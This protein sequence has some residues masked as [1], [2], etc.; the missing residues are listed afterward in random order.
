[1]PRIFVRGVVFDHGAGLPF[2]NPIDLDLEP[3]WT[4][5]VGP[6]G[7]GKTTLLRLITGELRP[8]A[9][10][11]RVEPGPARLLRQVPTL[12]AE[13]EAFAAD[14]SGLAG[15]LRSRLR[16]E[17]DQLR[18]WDTLSPGE[19]KCWQLGA[20]LAREPALLLCDEPGNHLDATAR[21]LM[22]DALRRFRGLGVIVSHERE[23]LDA[24]CSATVFVDRGGAIEPRRGAYSAALEQRELERG[25]L[26][27]E[28]E[29]EREHARAAARALDAARRRQ[30]ASARSLRNSSR[31]R[32]H[33]DHDASSAARKSRAEHA[34]ASAEAGVR[35]AQA[36]A[37]RARA[38][39][40]A[41]E[42]EHERHGGELFVDWE[43]PRKHTLV[44][45]DA[46][47]LAEYAPHPGTRLPPGEPAVVRRDDRIYLCGRNGAG[48]TSLLRAL[49]ACARERLD[50]IRVLWLPQE[51]DPDQRR[52]LLDE[53]RGLDRARRARVLQIVA[54]TGLDP[55]QLLATPDP[56]P[57]EARKL[58]LALGLARRAWLLLLDEPSNHL[59]LPSREALERMLASYPGA[60]V[61][62]SHDPRFAEALT[63]RVWRM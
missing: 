20:A 35:R 51:L 45:L 2:P 33:R 58:A 12:D 29:R 37:A 54:T 21:A 36:A 1:V 63:T 34:A 13:I 56:S 16:L 22:L 19:R 15:R 46:A 27:A 52:D 4:G 49:W 38:R 32:S 28:F 55:D 10:E 11:I 42:I 47:S 26:R 3:G 62:T 23:L 57:G 6:N 48:K 44:G 50:P 30:A 39:V 7:V 8:G 53:L 31:K 41:I 9:G 18:R 14:W 61:L 17:A 40:E 59:D 5:L 25:H 60:L 43:A 24:L